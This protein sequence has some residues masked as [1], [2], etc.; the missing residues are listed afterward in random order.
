MPHKNARTDLTAE[1]LR[2]AFSYDPLTGVLR[3]KHRAER[4]AQWNGRYGGRTV[5]S[6]VQ[7]GLSVS[8]DKK[9]YLIHRIIWVIM[10]GAW[11]P[12]EIDHEDCNYKNNV[13][14]NLRP[15]TASQ[16]MCNQPK[17]RNN[18]S[19]FKGIYWDKTRLHWRATIM[20]R[21]VSHYLGSFGTAIAAHAAYCEAAER[22]HGEFARHG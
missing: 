18:T 6:A 12:Y 20:C 14:T 1:F 17:R 10:T 21:G 8:I 22:L 9:R 16:N 2:S 4:S 13:W 3:W 11:P 7:R 5:G 19:G 15:A